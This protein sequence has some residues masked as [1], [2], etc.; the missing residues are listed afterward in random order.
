[1]PLEELSRFCSNRE[2]RISKRSRRSFFFSSRKA[3]R[4]ARMTRA[5]K[6]LSKRIDIGAGE[7]R[8]SVRLDGPLLGQSDFRAGWNA[9]VGEEDV[10]DENEENED[11]ILEDLPTVSLA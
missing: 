6:Q 11:S 2:N 1:M 10:L 5:K 9:G 4:S 7:L 3:L 8:K